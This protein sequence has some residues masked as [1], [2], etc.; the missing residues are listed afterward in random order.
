[1]REIFWYIGKISVSLRYKVDWE[2]K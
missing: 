1:L 2:T